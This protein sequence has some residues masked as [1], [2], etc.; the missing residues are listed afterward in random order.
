MSKKLALSIGEYLAEYL[1]LKEIPSLSCNPWTLQV[2]QV[3]IG[4]A[5]ELKRLN[6]AWYSKVSSEK[7]SSSTKGLSAVEL[8]NK[9]KEAYKKSETEWNALL[10]YRYILKEKYLPHTIKCRVP[11]IDFSNEKTNKII[12]KGLITALW[13][14]DFCEWSLKEEDIFFENEIHKYGDNDE[15]SMDF[16]WVTLKLSLEA[17]SSF[18]GDEWIEIKTPQK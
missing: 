15:Y 14:C 3:T 10:K 12:K 1:M 2:I 11:F 5:D 13:D 16:T 7:Y 9:E 8:Y 17:P 6:D 4:E 18:T